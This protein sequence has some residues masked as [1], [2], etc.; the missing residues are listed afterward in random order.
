MS[1]RSPIWNVAKSV[2]QRS[3][4]LHHQYYKANPDTGQIYIH[5]IQRDALIMKRR[6]SLTY[7]QNTNLGT[8]RHGYKTNCYGSPQWSQ[9]GYGC[10]FSLVIKHVPVKTISV[11][12][13]HYQAWKFHKKQKRTHLNC[14]C[15]PLRNVLDSKLR[16]L[17]ELYRNTN[18][19]GFPSTNLMIRRKDAKDMRYPSVKQIANP[20][21]LY[22][23]KAVARR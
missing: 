7:N 13:S 2:P 15:G 12:K 10:H 6:L 9:V 8:S 4:H 20:V 18:G 19:A 17:P 3:T 5:E 16:I 22:M 11:S 1:R 23:W 14:L 21:T